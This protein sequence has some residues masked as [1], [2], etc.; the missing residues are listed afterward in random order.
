MCVNRDLTGFLAF[1]GGLEESYD[2]SHYVWNA[3][4]NGVE[5][6]ET[7]FWVGGKYEHLTRTD[8]TFWH[9]K[10]RGYYD[11]VP[12]EL[13]P[14]NATLQQAI[15]EGRTCLAGHT[16]KYTKLY[17]M[18]C[19]EKLPAVCYNYRQTSKHN[20]EQ[21][22]GKVWTLF[23]GKCYYVYS[24]PTNDSRA[25]YKTFFDAQQECA[26]MGAIVATVTDE[27]T[28]KRTL[29]LATGLETIFDIDDG[30]WIGLQLSGRG[31]GGIYYYPN[32][33]TRIFK[34]RN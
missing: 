26:A 28:F 14:D 13:L 33:T 17:P 23:R 1:V 32:G 27:Q 34:K 25:G 12:R 19:D 31:F 16:E 10:Y 3:L 15:R 11:D 8:E 24:S 4:K 30:T 20:C 9:F 2:V 7:F 22:D 21:V 6:N 29:D 5:G 18:S